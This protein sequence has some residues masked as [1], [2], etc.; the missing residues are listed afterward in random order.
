MEEYEPANPRQ[1]GTL[2]APAV[3]PNARGFPDAVEKSR[4]A[5]GGGSGSR[6]SR[7]APPAQAY[8]TPVLAPAVTVWRIAPSPAGLK[9]VK[10]SI[11]RSP[12]R[13][14]LSSENVTVNCSVK[15]SPGPSAVELVTVTRE[16]L[17]PGMRARGPRD[18]ARGPVRRGRGTRKRRVWPA[19]PRAAPR[20]RA[21]LRGT[22][23]PG[24]GAL[25]AMGPQDEGG[26]RTGLGGEHVGVVEHDEPAVEQFP[27]LDAQAG[28]ASAARAW[29]QLQPAQPETHGVVS[30][31][32]A[33]LAAAEEQRQLPRGRPP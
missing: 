1:I 32:A 5:R 8:R 10:E 6:T 13:L 29:R 12:R 23:A 21:A 24:H 9:G 7:M 14:S 26:A 4:R 22:G 11:Q 19:T 3:M 18:G 16:T 30:G 20:R 25:A 15:M 27:E 28:P 17:A 2:G 33:G 31:H